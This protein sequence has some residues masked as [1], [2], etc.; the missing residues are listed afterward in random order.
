MKMSVKASS[1]SVLLAGILLA[2]SAPLYAQQSG[3][4]ETVPPQVVS[5]EAQKVLDRMSAYLRNLQNF[6]IAADSSRDEV[7]SHGYKLQHNEHSDLI[8]QRPNKLHADI[9]GDLRNRTI[10]YDGAKLAMYSPDDAAYVRVAAPNSIAE[11]TEGLLGAG[12]EMPMIDVLYQGATGT[13]TEAVHGGILVGDSSVDGVA[14]DH[15]AFRQD[16][17]DWQLW[18][19]QGDQ[20]LP[21][22]IVITTRYE[23]GDP[24]YQI[25]MNW[26]LK[27]K[28][29]A[30]TFVF[31]A[32][33][34]AT[35]IQ[36]T[37]PTAIQPNA[38]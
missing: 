30:S 31:T 13:L 37:E 23:V 26:N 10:V 9:S 36:F 14:C 24:Q 17:I 5:P 32:P 3:A 25:T 27:P 8:V 1:R 7:V 19:Q 22:K 29:D 18:V 4:T 15:L 20:P 28:I 11:L 12:V 35:E 6:S 38:Q 2:L 21:R 16:N 33:K 34:G